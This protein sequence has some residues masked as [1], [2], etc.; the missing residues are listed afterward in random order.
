MPYRNIAI[1]SLLLYG[2]VTG[3]PFSYRKAFHVSLAVMSATLL[4]RTLRVWRRASMEQLKELEAQ[5]FEVWHVVL[6]K[7]I[8]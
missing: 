3:S 7:L 2:H 1:A 6:S 5:L 4:A 8:R